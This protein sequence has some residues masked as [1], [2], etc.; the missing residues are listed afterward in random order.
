MNLPHKSASEQQQQRTYILIDPIIEDMV[1]EK[2]IPPHQEEMS[3]ELNDDTFIVNGKKQ[4]AEVLDRFKKK[5]LKKDGDYFK[6][7]RKNGSTSTTI[8]LN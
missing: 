8:H 7:T 4:S 3:F 5:Y 6:F 2:I 1:E